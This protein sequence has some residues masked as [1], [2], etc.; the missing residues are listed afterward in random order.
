MSTEAAPGIAAGA[1][2][3]KAAGA[4]L[5]IARIASVTTLEQQEQEQQ[6]REQKMQQQ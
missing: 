5:P 4:E 1:K 3:V 6:Q 2:A